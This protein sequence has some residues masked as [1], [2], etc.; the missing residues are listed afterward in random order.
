MQK[1]FLFEFVGASFTN[2]ENHDAVALATCVGGNM[3]ERFENMLKRYMPKSIPSSL[4][5]RAR[6]QDTSIGRKA[7]LNCIRTRTSVRKKRILC[8]N[9]EHSCL[10][11]VDRFT[12]SGFCLFRLVWPVLP[13]L[14]EVSF[15]SHN[16]LVVHCDRTIF[17]KMC[18][19]HNDQSMQHLR[20]LNR[21]TKIT[22]K[23]TFA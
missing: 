22:T 3:L 23:S 8:I 17:A 5:R 20:R 18:R 2:K 12:F 11:N 9:A 13:L 19:L 6:I 21:I 14:P 4:H 7:T 15:F 10:L 16:F 1:L